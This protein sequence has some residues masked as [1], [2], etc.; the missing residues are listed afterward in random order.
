MIDDVKADAENRMKKTIDAFKRELVGI[1]TGRAS[2][3][4]IEPLK[5]D[6][7]GTADA[8]ATD[9]RDLRARS[10]PARHQ[11]VRSVVVIRHRKSDPEIGSRADA[12]E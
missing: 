4:L 12:D 3:A 2:P 1:R 10:A 9:R 11:A 6:Y 5:V 8:A 7:Y